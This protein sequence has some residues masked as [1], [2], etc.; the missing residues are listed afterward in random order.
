M[1][2]PLGRAVGNA[3]EVD[4]VASRRSKGR[5]PRD[6][7]STLGASSRRGCSCSAGVAADRRRARAQVRD[8]LASG[9]GVEKFREIVANQGGDPRVVDDYAPAA[10]GAAIA[11]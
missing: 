4:R 6:L 7:E 2:A 3:L 11:T 1:D 5:G 8:A 10:V 9:A